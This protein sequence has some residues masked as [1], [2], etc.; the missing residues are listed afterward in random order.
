MGVVKKLKTI[1]IYGGKIVNAGLEGMLSGWEA[2]LDGKGLIPFLRQSARNALK[3]SPL[4][5][6][7]G[8]LR[9]CRRLAADVACGARMNLTRV[10]D[11][12]W[13][14]SHPIDYA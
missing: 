7:I 12:Q 10:R 4:G 13:L 2:S 6:C 11:E 1:A 14:R 9:G 5:A 3:P 8:I